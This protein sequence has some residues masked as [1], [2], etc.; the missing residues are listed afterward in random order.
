VS[1]IP[2]GKGKDRAFKVAGSASKS[3]ATSKANGTKTAAQKAAAKGRDMGDDCRRLQMQMD[4]AA[5]TK[6]NKGQ[7]AKRIRLQAEFMLNCVGPPSDDVGSGEYGSGVPAT[8]DYNYT[9]LAAADVTGDVDAICSAAGSEELIKRASNAT[10]VTNPP[11]VQLTCQAGSAV[12][13]FYFG[14]DSEADYNAAVA[15]LESSMGTTSTAGAQL[16]VPVDDVAVVYSSP[17]GASYYALVD[18][19]PAST[20]STPALVA[21]IAGACAFVLL[22]LCLWCMLCRN[23]GKKS[24]ADPAFNHA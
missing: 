20:L 5:T 15:A 1:V 17:E 21:I 4:N 22:L 2:G 12:L 9:V 16:S 13:A 24:N 10:N 14:F 8:F 19:A 23:K 6:D 18:A 11:A 3:L 7:I